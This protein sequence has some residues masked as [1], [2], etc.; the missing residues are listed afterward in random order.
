[1]ARKKGTEAE[2]VS[3]EGLTDQRFKKPQNA[4]IQKKKLDKTLSRLRKP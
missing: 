2:E 4:R 3:R 1:M